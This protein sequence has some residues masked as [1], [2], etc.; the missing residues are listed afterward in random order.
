MIPS[1]KS[2]SEDAPPPT[3]YVCDVPLPSKSQ[4]QDGATDS[5]LPGLIALQSEGTGFSAR[6]GN[7]VERSSVAFQ[8]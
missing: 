7:T 1:K 3:C 5:L 2:A 6:G 4:K 8:C